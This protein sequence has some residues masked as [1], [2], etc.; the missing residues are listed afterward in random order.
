MWHSGHGVALGTYLLSPMKDDTHF[1]APHF[2]RF[3][4]QA[5]NFACGI[6]ALPHRIN[7][8]QSRLP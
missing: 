6:S 7:G 1:T 2:T 5:E 8:A 3:R 4:R